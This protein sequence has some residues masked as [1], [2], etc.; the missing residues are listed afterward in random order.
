MPVLV[1]RPGRSADTSKCTSGCPGI[2]HPAMGGAPG[3]S[4]FACTSSVGTGTTNM[5]ATAAGASIVHLPVML[6]PDCLGCPRYLDDGEVPRVETARNHVGLERPRETGVT[7]AD[8]ERDHLVPAHV[9]PGRG[10]RYRVLAPL[11]RARRSISAFANDVDTV[12]GTPIH[13]PRATVVPPNGRSVTAPVSSEV[14]VHSKTLFIR[15]IHYYPNTNTRGAA[16]SEGG[17]IQD[18]KRK[19][20]GRPVAGLLRYPA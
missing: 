6:L 4:T 12:T 13:S 10:G 16:C 2:R 7:R 18:V 14:V 17:T 8:Q 3:V 9:D 19:A 20:Y 11:S 15:Q 5:D 1:V